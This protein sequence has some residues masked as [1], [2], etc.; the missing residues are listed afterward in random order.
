[1]CTTDM[2]RAFVQLFLDEGWGWGC[3]W[4]STKDAM[5][6]SKAPGEGGNGRY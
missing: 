6:F 2:P 5:H 1:V 3:N 4:N